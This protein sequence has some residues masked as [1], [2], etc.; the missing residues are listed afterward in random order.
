MLPSDMTA[1]PLAAIIAHKAGEGLC[2]ETFNF[3]IA[4]GQIAHA[5]EL[6]ESAP[7]E[8]MG[9]GSVLLHNVLQIQRILMDARMEA[10]T[11]A[12]QARL[13]RP[14]GASGLVRPINT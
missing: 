8:A 11:R 1:W 13:L 10:Q 6:I 14:V 5:K 7:S 3:L 2:L 9:V 12:Q 4:L